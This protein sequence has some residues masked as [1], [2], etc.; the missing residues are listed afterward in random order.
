[1]DLDL[2]KLTIDL[3]ESLAYSELSKAAIPPRLYYRLRAFLNRTRSKQLPIAQ[4]AQA[5]ARKYEQEVTAKNL[6]KNECMASFF[7]SGELR[8]D[9]GA[10]VPEKVKKAAML[11]AKKRGLKAVEASLTK[12][13]GSN[14]YVRFSLTDDMSADSKCLKRM[15]WNF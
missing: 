5:M 4:A 10:E 7:D 3:T 15:R 11:W 9:F 2:D 13:D 12:S 1:M 14:S 6:S 8:F